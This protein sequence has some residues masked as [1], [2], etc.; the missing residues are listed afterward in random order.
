MATKCEAPR[1]GGCLCARI[2]Y[3]LIL[4]EEHAPIPYELTP[5]GHREVGRMR[6][7]DAIKD[8]VTES[9]KARAAIT[10]AAMLDGRKVEARVRRQSK[11]ESH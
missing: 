1:L 5:R 2:G 8:S 10:R 11:Q 6:Q 4:C 7:W 3:M 9:A